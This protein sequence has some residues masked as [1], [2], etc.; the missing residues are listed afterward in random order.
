M[1]MEDQKKGTIISISML[2]GSLVLAV[3]ASIVMPEDLVRSKHD[4]NRSNITR[5]NSIHPAT[6]NVPMVIANN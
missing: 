2:I 6:E 3:I 4:E 5:A 1:T